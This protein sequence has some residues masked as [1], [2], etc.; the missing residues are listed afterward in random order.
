MIVRETKE[1]I[2][3][4]ICLDELHSPFALRNDGSYQ[5]TFVI[6]NDNHFCFI[7]AGKLFDV[8]PTCNNIDPN[9]LSRGSKRV[10]NKIYCTYDIDL[11]LKGWINEKG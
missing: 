6:K 8:L 4:D 2:K 7:C 3:C 9:E 1:M 10:N 11:K 5:N